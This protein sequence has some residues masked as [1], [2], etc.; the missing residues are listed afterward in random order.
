M[1]DRKDKQIV[2]QVFDSSLSGIQDDPW[3][4]QRVLSKA[5]EAPGTGGFIVKKKMSAG[6]IFAI[7]MILLTVTAVAAVLLTHTEIIEQFAVPM[8]LENDTKDTTQETYTNEEL[9]QLI[10][11]LS[12]NGITL[13]EDTS[14]MNALENGEGYWEE[15][16]LMAICRE[17]FGGNFS[18]WSIEEKHWFDNMT[19]QIGFKEKN[20]YLIPGE[21]DMSIQEAKT[22]AAK[23]LKDKYGVELPVENNEKWMIWEWFYA[24]WTDTEG[25]HPA[26][27]KF[28][29]V[30]RETNMVVY[31]AKFDRDGNVIELK[32]LPFSSNSVHAAS[33]NDANM[34]IDQKY[35]AMGA[36]SIEGWTEFGQL[37]AP[38][39]PSSQREWAHQQAGYCVP[40]TGSL[41][42]AAAL[43]IA[44]DAIK[45]GNE[46]SYQIICCTDGGK[47]IYKLTLRY[48]FPENRVEHRYDAIWCVEMDCMT[49][50]ITAIRENQPDDTTIQH[51]LELFV[52]FS[53][54]DRMPSF[55]DSNK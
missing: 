12:E 7:V 4:A 41:D 15:E 22:Y 17:A 51:H 47:P 1:E 54:L 30:D 42:E 20:P 52:P 38:F 24:P 53:V 8:A 32:G 16:T 13:D 3:M 14:I 45:L 25:N 33:F 5:H 55:E 46:D 9:V 10:A 43:H 40:P 34:Y 48:E 37:I 21:G 49:G 2:Q 18:T 26:T 19:V 23:L 6:L 44:R 28:E 39:E 50:E 31:S 35:G 29:Y 27:W 36:W 11:I